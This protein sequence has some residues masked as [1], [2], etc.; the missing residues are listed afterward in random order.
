MRASNAKCV[1][2]ARQA[3]SRPERERLGSKAPIS[4]LDTQ[5]PFSSR[6]K[7]N[8][9]RQTVVKK[10]TPARKAD[11]DAGDETPV[12]IWEKNETP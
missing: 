10:H 11:A 9:G 12:W 2:W 5:P 4:G 1:G 7:E 3:G 8:A 6:Q